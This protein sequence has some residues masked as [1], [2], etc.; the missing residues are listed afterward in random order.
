MSGQ[1]KLQLMERVASITIEN[2]AAKNA[3]TTPMLAAI[4]EIVGSLASD[5]GVG[6]V[7]FRGAGS[8]FCSGADMG[9]LAAI[10][11]APAPQRSAAFEEG[12]QTQIQPLTRAL[13]ALPQ[14]VVASIRGHAIGIGALFVLAADLVVASDTA[15]ITVPQVR[16]GHTMDHGESWLL[17]RK[18]GLSKALQLALLGERMTAVDAERFGLVNWVTR[19]K[20]LDDRTGQVVQAL[21]TFSPS[22]VRG[23]KSLLRR[24]LDASLDEQL[25][26]EVEYASTC[27]GTAEFVEAISAQVEKR[28]PNFAGT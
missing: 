2:P 17:P 4:T 28:A 14:P 18:V 19:D 20:D 25:R 21:L 1:V 3:L 13:L 16:L 22:A 7:V 6:V 9:D 12:M 27:A 5:A 11:S 8:D 26:T 23:A 15:K 10:L 24:S